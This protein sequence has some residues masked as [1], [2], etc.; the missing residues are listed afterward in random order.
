MTCADCRAEGADC[1]TSDRVR[2]CSDCLY[3]RVVKERDEARAEL[4]SIAQQLELEREASAQLR[5]EVGERM[6][7]TAEAQREACAEA[8]KRFWGVS[9]HNAEVQ[10]CRA[11]PLVT[12]GDK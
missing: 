2:V 7:E 5:A 3:E 12:K 11:T 9:D 8:V 4:L 1:L 6:R 10:A